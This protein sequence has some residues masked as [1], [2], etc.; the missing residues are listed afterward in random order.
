MVTTVEATTT[1]SAKVVS[2]ARC[3][4]LR[5]YSAQAWSRMV[6][7]RRSSELLDMV[8]VLAPGVHGKDVAPL[9]QQHDSA[10]ISVRGF[11]VKY[12]RV[13]VVKHSII[14]DRR[15]AE[16]KTVEAEERTRTDEQPD[17]QG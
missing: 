17:A 1:A 10:K 16:E 14:S 12:V 9:I 15:C 4:V 8:Q 5:A 11:V 13:L 7:R 6:L 3:D 2:P